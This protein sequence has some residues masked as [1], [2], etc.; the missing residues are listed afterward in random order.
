LS[1][2]L[3]K[4]WAYVCFMLALLA[5]GFLSVSAARAADDLDGAYRK[6]VKDAGPTTSALVESIDLSEFQDYYGISLSAE[7]QKLVRLALMSYSNGAI[8]EHPVGVNGVQRATLEEDPYVGNK[9]TNKFHYSWCSSVSDM[10]EKNK[11]TFS[12]RE[13]AIRQEYVP[14]K[15]CN[16]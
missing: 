15:K 12:S 6:A 9:K 5:V 4:A 14:C 2:I 10:K 13:D 1:R 8:L 7:E 3:K 16:P 11:V